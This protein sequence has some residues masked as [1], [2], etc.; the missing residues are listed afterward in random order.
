M[1]SANGHVVEMRFF[2]GNPSLNLPFKSASYYIF[3][4]L[5]LCRR[6]A[7]LRDGMLVSYARQQKIS[8]RLETMFHLL[9]L[10]YLTYNMHGPSHCIISFPG[11]LA[12]S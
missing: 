10:L 3:L 2:G 4:A 8:G 1:P 11:F 7:L 6:Y 9:V 12:A 5:T